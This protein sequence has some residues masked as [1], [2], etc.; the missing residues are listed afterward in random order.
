MQ[1]QV[2]TAAAAAETGRPDGSQHNGGKGRSLIVPG[3]PL[4]MSMF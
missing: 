2:Q 4:W 3:L 1:I